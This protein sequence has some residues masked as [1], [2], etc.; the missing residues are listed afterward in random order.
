MELILASGSPR[1]IELLRRL[2]L[3]FQVEVSEADESPRPGERPEA[4]VRRLAV[5]KAVLVARRHPQAVVLA[6]DTTVALGERILGKPADP[7]EAKAMLSLLSGR[8]HQV[9]SGVA[10]YQEARGRGW[11]RTAVAQVTFRTL[12]E[13]EI[14]AYIA[15][16]EPMDK[17]GAYAIQG[18]AGG[19]VEAFQGDLEAVIGLPL[20]LVKALLRHFAD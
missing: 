4:M 12:S 17:A 5:L 16:G 3:P 8:R 11:V 10:A 15:T 7:Q 1:R 18:G 14:L 13:E 9:Y 20:D 6:A 19:F 2:H